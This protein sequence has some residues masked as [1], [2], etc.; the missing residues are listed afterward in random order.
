[1]LTAI[2]APDCDQDRTGLPGERPDSGPVEQ[3]AGGGRDVVGVN[4]G[5][6]EQLGA[7]P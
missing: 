1:L 7:R 2:G 3:A 4:A 6:G 5:P